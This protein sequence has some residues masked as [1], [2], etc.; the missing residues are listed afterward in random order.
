MAKLKK[1][2]WRVGIARDPV[3]CDRFFDSEWEAI[4]K[5]TVMAAVYGF[6]EPIAIWD[7]RDEPAWIF[8]LGAQFRRT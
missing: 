8:M 7:E 4:E 5:A 3:P 6:N 1:A 2:P